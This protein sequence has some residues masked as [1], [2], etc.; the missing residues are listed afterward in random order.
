[1]G[2]EPVALGGHRE[3]GRAEGVAVFR[4]LFVF[5]SR[6]VVF[7]SRLVRD[8]RAELS[9]QP[10]AALGRVLLRRDL[11]R[12]RELRALGLEQIA[13][14]GVVDG[15]ERARG[16][17]VAQVQS[18]EDERGRL[19][20]APR[21]GALFARGLN[22][23]AAE[24][25]AQRD[26]LAQP[27]FGGLDR[28][29]QGGVA[30]LEQAAAHGH[31]L[32]GAGALQR[33]ARG[34]GGARPGIERVDVGLGVRVGPD[35][36]E[37]V[38]EGARAALVAAGGQLAHRAANGLGPLG[39]QHALHRL[40]DPRE[41]EPAAHGHDAAIGGARPEPRGGPG[42]LPRLDGA[43]PRRALDRPRRS[44]QQIVHR[45]RKVVVAHRGL[46]RHRTFGYRRRGRGPLVSGAGGETSN[47]A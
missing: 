24:A 31:P 5:A 39:P 2:I 38:V 12:D 27:V 23:G 6:L 30:R 37:E 17:R 3:G 35:V 9:E 43:E 40:S 22:V 11:E 36:Q 18:R 47:R 10:D 4:E 28:V 25:V 26:G 16:V 13:R 14:L 20:R 21:L 33:A 44:E 1:M 19:E 34:D 7:V 42:H 41:I 32:E 8:E 46:R 15:G 29:A 45:D